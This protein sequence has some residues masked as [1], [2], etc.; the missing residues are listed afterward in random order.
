MAKQAAAR[1]E[2]QKLGRD[3]STVSTSP[4]RMR[5]QRT[6]EEA[7]NALLFTPKDQHAHICIA[8]IVAIE[9]F[10][11]P[12]S[13]RNLASTKVPSEFLAVA[14]IFLN[15]ETGD[16]LNSPKEVKQQGRRAAT[17]FERAE[18]NLPGNVAVRET[19]LMERVY[20]HTH[21]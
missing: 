11:K 20:K 4:Q 6:S 7:A 12:L 3:P 5:S 2:V 17:R 1:N 10:I 16:L 19:N 14:N 9:M 18:Q 8:L 21:I 13:A 15:V